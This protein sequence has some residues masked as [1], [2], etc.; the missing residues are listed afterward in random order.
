MNEKMVLWRKFA[1]ILIL[2][3]IGVA[4]FSM[5]DTGLQWYIK[6]VE[7]RP[8]AKHRKEVLWQTHNMYGW[9]L[10]HKKSAAVLNKYCWLYGINDERAPQARFQMAKKYRNAGLV[11]EAIK[12]YE[13]VIEYFPG[14]PLAITAQDELN[15]L[16]AAAQDKST[17]KL[18]PDAEKPPHYL[19]WPEED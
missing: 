8:L 1:L 13:H 6:K 16:R 2:A 3:A 7:E 14:Q 9:R 18:L 15:K 12:L 17:H 11:G 5:T 4:L 19:E 10:D